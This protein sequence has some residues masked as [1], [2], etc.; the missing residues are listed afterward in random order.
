MSHTEIE[1]G[2]DFKI[3]LT[4]QG[5]ELDKIENDVYIQLTNDGWFGSKEEAEE[6]GGDVFFEAV[7]FEAVLYYLEALG[8]T[9]TLE[10]EE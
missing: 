1:L 4:T 6:W 2:D 10:E 3:E 8:I 7:F 5:K 9:I